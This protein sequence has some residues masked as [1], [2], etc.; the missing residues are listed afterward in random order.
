[1]KEPSPQA[2]DRRLAAIM[3]IDMVGF[4]ALTQR[5]ETLALQ[6]LEEQRN[7]IRPLLEKHKGREV[8]TTG[9]GFL[10][11]FASSLEAVRCAVE[12]QSILEEENTRRP[13]GKKFLVRI[14]IHLGDVI[15]SAADVIGDA[16]MCPESKA[17]LACGI[18]L[19]AQ[20]TQRRQ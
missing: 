3:F 7:Q 9:D 19:T 11:E 20:V 16:V 8:K 10:V 4:A 12:I 13:E 14:G 18:C 17:W 1:M 5:N 15:H 6:L 2:G